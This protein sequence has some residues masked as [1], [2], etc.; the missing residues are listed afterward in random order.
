MSQVGNT[1]LEELG[2]DKFN[3]LN[4]DAEGHDFKVIS[5][6]N[7]DKYRPQLISIEHNSYNLD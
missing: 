3:F 7:F 1:L 2:I 6:F 4:I 5:N